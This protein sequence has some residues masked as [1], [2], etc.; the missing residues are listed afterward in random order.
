M[1]P[2][3][4]IDT[5]LI[6]WIRMGTTVATNALLERK[7]ERMAL[8]VT[9]GFKDVLFI[10]NQARPSLFDLEI[11]CPEVLYE[12]VVE[13]DERLEPTYYIYTILRYECMALFFVCPILL[14]L[15]LLLIVC[16]CTMFKH[17]QNMSYSTKIFLL[18][19]KY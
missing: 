17:Q 4:P 8:V 7:G 11:R 10:G 1:S 18:L 3:Q 15:L 14:G 5:G 19:D 9:K 6:Q 2:D 13:V 12:E 16:L